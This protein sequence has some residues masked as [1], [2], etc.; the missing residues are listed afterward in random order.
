MKLLP[1][2]YAAALV[3]ELIVLMVV[4]VE[5]PP[6]SS[7]ALSIYLGWAGLV[8]MVVMLI[9]SVARRS[10]AFRQWA[11]LSAWL[12]FHIFMGVQGFVLTLFHSSHLLRRDAPLSWLN[13][14]LLSLIAVLVVFFSGIYGR[15]M[16]SWLPRT[17]KGERMSSEEARR[18]LESAE[19]QLPPDVEA[20]L[21]RAIA[22]PSPSFVALVRADI[23]ARRIRRRCRALI[24][25]PTLRDL[26]DRRLLLQRRLLTLRAAE[27]I[28]RLWII[29]H[30]PLAGIMYVLA[31]VHVGLAYMFT[32]GL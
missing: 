7:S 24:A 5:D 9:Y 6:A 10:K 30:R 14:G 22:P 11:R 3:V 25:D 15:Y 23:E 4:Y 8:A 20:E 13:P 21:D 1:L 16:Y 28:F 32:P 17:M 12:H 19:V 26:V 27:R 29:A 18:E 31:A 2:L